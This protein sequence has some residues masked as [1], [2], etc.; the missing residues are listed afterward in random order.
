VEVDEEV[1]KSKSVC[2]QERS[3]TKATGNDFT[4]NGKVINCVYNRIGDNNRSSCHE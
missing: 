1:V 4:S 3:L 2:D